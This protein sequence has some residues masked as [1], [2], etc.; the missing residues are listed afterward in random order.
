MAQFYNSIKTMKTARVGTILP[1]AGD[2][3]KGFLPPRMSTTQRN[4][5]S[6]PVSG[7]IIY[8]T[9]TGKL[10]LYGASYWEEISSL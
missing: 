8:N 4:N 7:L 9:T 3:N 10:N 6:G 2:G 1:W 5:I